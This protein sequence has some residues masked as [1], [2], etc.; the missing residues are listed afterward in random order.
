MRTDEDGVPCIAQQVAYLGASR[1]FRVDFFDGR[2][3]TKITLEHFELEFCVESIEM[4]DDMAG[5]YDW[6][7][8]TAKSVWLTRPG[9]HRLRVIRGGK[10]G[11]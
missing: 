4:Q 5:A 9:R 7:R 1:E 2:L 3:A 11:G 6:L 8:S 10:A